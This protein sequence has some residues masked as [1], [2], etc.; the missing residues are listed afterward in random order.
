[1]NMESRVAK[2]EEQAGISENDCPQ[3]SLVETNVILPHTDETKWQETNRYEYN[4]PCPKCG[5]PREISVRVI[6]PRESHESAL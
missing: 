6:Q 1:M 5:R 4:V 3:C 2:L